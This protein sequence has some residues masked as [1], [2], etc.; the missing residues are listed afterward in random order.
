MT[1]PIFIGMAAVVFLIGVLFVVKG[2]SSE[3][4][5][6]VPISSPEEIQKLKSAFAPSKSPDP[7]V[8]PQ[9]EKSTETQGQNIQTVEENHQLR[10]DLHDQKGRFEQ[11]E[12]DMELLK[13]EHIQIQDQKKKEVEALE[14]EKAQFDGEKELL[15][16]KSGLLSELKIKTEML[17]RQHEEAQKQRIEMSATVNQ[18]KAEKDNLVMQ[19]KLREDQV[20]IQLKEQRAEASK[21][22]FES[23]SS[24]LVESIA[25]IAEL[26]RENKDLQKENLDLKDVFKETEELNNHLI[27]KEKM[28]HYELTKNRAQALGLEKICEDFRMR[29]E[30]MADAAPQ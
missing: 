8:L 20:A 12:K 2:I 18:L 22:E 4:Q 26:K 23:L 11:L 1:I 9:I 21:A 10:K 15:S 13:A 16:S 29:I 5:E 6:A 24:K 25:A 19:T 7:V 14:K 17:E 30:I 3:E 28:M 27:E